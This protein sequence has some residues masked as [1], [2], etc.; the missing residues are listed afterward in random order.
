[1]SPRRL[2]SRSALRQ[3]TSLHLPLIDRHCSHSHTRSDKARRDNVGLALNVLSIWAIVSP[4]NSQPHSRMPPYISSTLSVKCVP[5]VEHSWRF[6]SVINEVGFIFT[7]KGFKPCNPSL[8]A[9]EVPEPICPV[10]M[11]R[12]LCYLVKMIIK[13]SFY[14]HGIFVYERGFPEWTFSII[15]VSA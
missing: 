7:Y 10:P 14:F 4:L 5:R 3:L 1:M 11:E 9:E 13:R 12:Q 6:S 8:L 2:S 15:L